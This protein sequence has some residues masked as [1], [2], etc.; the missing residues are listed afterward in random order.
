MEIFSNLQK[1]VQLLA[2]MTD[3]PAWLCASRGDC[4]R[5]QMS[6]TP[7]MLHVVWCSCGV[8][9]L[10]AIWTV[11]KVSAAAIQPLLCTAKAQCGRCCAC[12][13][14]QLW[15]PTPQD[16]LGGFKVL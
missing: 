7:E 6:L 8:N 1:L 5:L 4:G 12:Y 2:W 13:L 3:A 11:S 14:Q 15:H 10:E 16:Q 9:L